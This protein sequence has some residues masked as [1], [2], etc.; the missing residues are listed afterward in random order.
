M[1][2]SLSKSQ[3]ASVAQ[4]CTVTG[5]SEAQAIK[6]LRRAA[7]S[8]EAST[9]AFLESGEEPAGMG[10][11][12]AAEAEKEFK[13][14]EDR[15]EKGVMNVEGME[16][17]CKELGL[18]LYSSPLILVLCF[19]GGAQRQGALTAA[20]FAKLFAATGVKS[21]AGLKAALHM[22]AAELTKAPFWNWVYSFSCAEGQRAIEKDVAESL[23]RMLAAQWALLPSFLAFFNAQNKSITKDT[24]N[25]L[26]SFLK[27]F[28]GPEE[29][30]KG[31]DEADSWPVMLDDFQTWTVKNKA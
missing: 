22:Q 5:A 12:G 6:A 29:L 23:L 2:S 20:E 17:L 16:A 4:F 14:F 1:S 27:R 21:V 31:W 13:R 28:P 11:G 8:V 30:R 3:K 24:W 18:D 25:L 15:V 10:G 9:D 7:W 19:K 26:L